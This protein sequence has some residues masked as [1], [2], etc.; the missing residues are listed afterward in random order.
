MT[1]ARAFS[2]QVPSVQFDPLTCLHYPTSEEEIVQL[3]QY[4]A[5]NN[6]QVRVMGSGHSVREAILSTASNAIN[7]SLEQYRKVTSNSDGTFTVQAGCC[8]GLD[9]PEPWENTFFYQLQQLA[10]AVPDMGGV[11]HQAVGGFTTMGCSGARCSTPTPTALSVSPWWMGRAWCART[12]EG[13]IRSS[14]PCSFP[15][16]SWASPPPSP[17]SPTMPSTS[18]GAR[19][20]TP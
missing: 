15:W 1:V 6:L 11:T 20:A 12:P 4:A 17:S 9:A 7:I 2:P 18:S 3:V 19:R 10:Q 5:S 8:L 16:G 14:R 13:R